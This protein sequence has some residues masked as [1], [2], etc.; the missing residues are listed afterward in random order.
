MLINTDTLPQNRDPFFLADFAELKTIINPDACFSLSDFLGSVKR[1]SLEKNRTI[2][3]PENI[4]NDITSFVNN[5]KN[6]FNDAYPF[7]L[8]KNENSIIFEYDNS[9]QQQFYLFLLMASSLRLIEQHK[10]TPITRTFEDASYHVFKHLMPQNAEI[11]AVGAGCNCSAYKGTL[12]EK[13]KNI[14]KDIRCIPNFKEQDFKRTDT[15]DGGIDLIAWH[16]ME[17]QREGIPIAFAQCGCSPTEWESKQLEASPASLHSKLPVH[18][19]WATYYFLPLDL[20]RHDGDWGCKSD[21]HAAI[22][23]DRLRLTRLANRH[24]IHNSLSY[25]T[26]VKEILEYRE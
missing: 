5:R 10:R 1:N 22:F 13:M 11:R 16:S 3:E 6:N 19:P 4:W 9:S 21:M 15:G 7:K 12:F 25:S 2:N 20:R 18:H 8:S 14:A 17:D 24:S 23:V 26:I